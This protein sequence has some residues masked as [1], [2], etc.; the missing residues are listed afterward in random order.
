VRLDTI[1]EEH[2]SWNKA[3]EEVVE[4][5]THEL[6]ILYEQLQTK[7]VMCKRLL[8]KV[9]TTQEEERARLARE[10]HDAIGQSLTA[11]ILTTTSIE[12]SLPTTFTDGKKKLANVRNIAT[13]S[14]QDLRNLIF[15]LRPEILDDLGLALAVRS[16]VKKYLEPAG[17][18]VQLR[19]TGLK[20]QLSAEVER[21][22]FRVVQEAITN[23][24]RHAHA[25][26]A[27]ISLTKKDNR[28]IVRIEDN[29]LGFDCDSVRHWQR[30]AWGLQGMEERITLLG[31]EFYIG[32]KPG[33]GTLVLAEIPLGQVEDLPE[34]NDE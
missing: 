18:Q 7:E 1:L 26:E 30:Q 19:A 10:L 23:I 31:G 25:S 3:L 6:T 12:S 2:H 16:Q 32:S 24:A 34:R 4:E 11:I 21:A 17:V 8:G 15:D 5:R 20:D 9:L 13:Q 33:N 14:L 28:L 29:G 27:S 22:V